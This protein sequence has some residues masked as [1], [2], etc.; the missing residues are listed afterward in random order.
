MRFLIYEISI[1]PHLIIQLEPQL[2]SVNE[3]CE[4]LIPVTQIE[5]LSPRKRIISPTRSFDVL[6]VVDFVNVNRGEEPVISQAI[7]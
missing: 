4:P 7:L 5:C 1:T 2:Q 6:S 3:I